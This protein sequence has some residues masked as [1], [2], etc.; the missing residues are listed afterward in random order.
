MVPLKAFSQ[1]RLVPVKRNAGNRQQT[2]AAVVSAVTGRLERIRCCSPHVWALS[3]YRF[4]GNHFGSGCTAACRRNGAGPARGGDRRAPAGKPTWNG[5]AERRGKRDRRFRHGFA[6]AQ[7]HRAGEFGP[8]R[9]G[10]AAV[11]RCGEQFGL[12]YGRARCGSV[13]GGCGAAEVAAAGAGASADGR[14][15]AHRAWRRCWPKRSSDG[16]PNR[17]RS[18]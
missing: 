2:L 16:A 17:G 5:R 18:W 4:A 10:G 9:K 8:G 15:S 13:E 6:D 1:H 11:L 7:R 14:A 12:V 3:F